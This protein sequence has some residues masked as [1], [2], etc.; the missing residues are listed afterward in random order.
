MD[1]VVVFLEKNL[2]TKL[3]KIKSIILILCNLLIIGFSLKAQE[4]NDNEIDTNKL[5]FPNMYFID[6]INAESDG[7]IS[8]KEFID[9]RMRT[10]TILNSWYSEQL[11]RLKE[12]KLNQEYP[13]EVYRFTWF[14]YLAHKHN[15]FSLRLECF[16]DTVFLFV[17]YINNQ[18]KKH[19]Y[20]FITDTV[21][22]N[23][24][25]WDIFKNKIDS[26]NFWSISPIEKTETVIMDGSVWILEGKNNKSYHMVHRN[27]GKHKEIGELCLFLLEKSRIKVKKKNLY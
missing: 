27:C 21:T 19:Q 24:N 25:D 15:P 17:N 1:L 18:N 20:E 22:L 5:F 2:M 11:L 3:M 23:K 10:A 7:T 12:P 14:G 13:H 26:L 8:G 9:R 6:T 4:K 16:N